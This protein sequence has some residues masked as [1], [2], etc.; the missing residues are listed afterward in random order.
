MILNKKAKFEYEFI[1]TYVAGLVLT[2]VDV[3]NIRA[4][5]FP[6]VDAYCS[7]KGDEL[8]LKDVKCLLNR[9][10]LNKLQSSLLKGLT[11]VPYKVFESNGKFKLELSLARGK[12]M[13]DKRE[14]IKKRDIVREISKLGLRN[15][16]TYI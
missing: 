12:K 5:K 10:E 6:L 7:F 1:D 3:K 13:S 8:F 2:G 14:T 11:I 16:K 15:S 4:G 9:K